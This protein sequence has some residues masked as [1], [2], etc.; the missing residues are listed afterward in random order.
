MIYFLALS[1]VDSLPDS[2][3]RCFP[4]TYISFRYHVLLQRLGYLYYFMSLSFY[5]DSI[6]FEKGDL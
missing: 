3:N 5:V 4:S 2:S 1:N 6:V